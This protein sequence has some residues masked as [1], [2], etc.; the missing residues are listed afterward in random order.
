MTNRT[1]DPAE[2]LRRVLAAGFDT[3]R[4]KLDGLDEYELRRPLVPTGTNL[5]GLAKHVALVSGEYFGLVFD[6]TS[7]LPP[8]P[9][10]EPNADMWATADE[11]ASFVLELLATAKAEAEATLLDLPLDAPG[12]VP[13][14]GA[15]RGHVTLLDVT[16]HLIAEIN[17]HVGHADIVRELIDGEVGLRAAVSNLPSAE[18]GVNDQWWSN[19]RAQL[20][21][22]AESFR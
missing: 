12:F 6:R 14:W 2:T 18:D 5:L 17:R 16:V 20:E 9:E 22:V 21:A 4:W 13:W 15:D 1:A 3:L 19:Y 7:A 11:S 8:P 10:D